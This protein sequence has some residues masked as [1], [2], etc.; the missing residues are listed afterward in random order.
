MDN[1]QSVNVLA[2]SSGLGFYPAKVNNIPQRPLLKT[3]YSSSSANTFTNSQ[4]K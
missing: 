2:N 4:S 1:R 3:A